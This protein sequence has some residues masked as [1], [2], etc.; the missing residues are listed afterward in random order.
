MSEK[1]TETP[2]PISQVLIDLKSQ[3]P[4]DKVCTFDILEALHERGF[5]FLIFLF[6]L[7]AALPL[8]AVGYGTLLSIPLLFLTAQQAIGRHTIWIPQKLKYKSI[9][10]ANFEAMVNKATPFVQ[11]IEIL[12]RPRLGFITQG[13]FSHIIGILGIIMTASIA[14]PLPLT[15]TVPAFGIALM[16]IGVIMR[17]GL[18]VIAGA[19]IGTAW[20]AMVAFVLIFIGIEG[21]DLIKETI[22][23]W[24]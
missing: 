2:R 7:P 19:L 11:K 1:N 24:L 15:N 3:V 22:K 18:A 21:I 12:I 10:R 20:V 17:D 6:A 23:G 14:I 8:P 13:V 5:G 9:T 4:E 16:A